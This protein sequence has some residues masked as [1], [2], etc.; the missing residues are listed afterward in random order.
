MIPLLR[1]ETPFQLRI[2]LIHIQENQYILLKI[3]YSEKKFLF[4][5]NLLHRIG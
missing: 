1:N 2:I 3:I 5:V 4:S